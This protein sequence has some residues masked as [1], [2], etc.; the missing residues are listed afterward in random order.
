MYEAIK[1]NENLNPNPQDVSFHIWNVLAS[2]K[3]VKLYIKSMVNAK[4][5]V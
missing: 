5:D 1:S 3:E 2:L 4:M